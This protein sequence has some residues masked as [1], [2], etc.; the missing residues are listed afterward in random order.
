MALHTKEPNRIHLD[1]VEEQV[2]ERTIGSDLACRMLQIEVRKDLQSTYV[3]NA[4]PCMA[5]LGSCRS[6]VD[7]RLK[8]FVQL[9]MGRNLMAHRN[10]RD[11]WGC[12]RVQFSR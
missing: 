9:Q 10:P 6:K 7:S 1:L 2:A 11:D 12:Y 8:I 5:E 4:Y 3:L